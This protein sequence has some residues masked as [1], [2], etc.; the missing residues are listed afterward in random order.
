MWISQNKLE[1]KIQKAIENY[2]NSF[3]LDNMKEF[4]KS[5]KLIEIL[6]NQHINWKFIMERDIK[7]MITPPNGIIL[8]PFM[9]SGSTGVASVKNNYSFI[10][11]EKE[12]DY[13]EI[14]KAR[15]EY[16]KK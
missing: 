5:I 12:Q 1:Y 10:G 6:T 9:G 11:I 8:D 16:H 4:D 3:S 13:M 15:I 14:S 2:K 7:N